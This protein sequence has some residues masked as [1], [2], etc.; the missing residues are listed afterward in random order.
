MTKISPAGFCKKILREMGQSFLSNLD[1]IPDVFLIFNFECDRK[2][3]FSSFYLEINNKSRHRRPVT[4]GRLEPI[5]LNF[6]GS[7][8]HI[9][10]P[11]SVVATL[12]IGERA[13]A[14]DVALIKPPR[15]RANLSGGA[16]AKA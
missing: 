9:Q 5:K 2:R 7:N 15:V 4:Q 10:F 13:G 8:L 12:S 1:C 16:H 14:R 3:V 11:D 6:L